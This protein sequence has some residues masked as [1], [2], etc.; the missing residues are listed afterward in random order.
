VTNIPTTMYVQTAEGAYLAYQ[1]LGSGPTDLVLP[2]NGG[3]PVDLM[4]EEPAIAL[5]ISR[6][7]SFSRVITFDPRG[8]GSSSGV[9]PEHVPAV[10]TWMDDIGT[11]MDAV[12]SD[13]ANLLAWGEYS[14]AVMLFAA[15]YPQRVINLVLVN[16]YAR[17]LRSSECPWGMPPD[18]F[19]AYIELIKAAWGTGAVTETLAPSMVQSEEVRMRWARAE[20]LSAAPD[21]IAIPRAFM[22][23]DVTGVV[24]AIQA[25][26]LL[27]SRRGDR[28]VRPEHSRFLATRIS[29][30]RLVELSGD[31]DFLFAGRVDE[32]I[33]NVQ[34]FVTGDRPGPLVDRVLA[35][36]LFTD[37]VGSTATVTELGD[38]LW[39]DLLTMHNDVVRQE[40][41]R[42]RG[43]EIDTAGDGFLI[44]FD[45]PARAIQ[46]G[47]AIRDR[48]RGLGIDI[49]AGLHTGEIMSEGDDVRG[50][51][52]H[53]GARVAALAGASEVLV[54]RTVVD[55]VAGSGI[56]F[57]DRGEH[58]L[59]GVPGFW[60]LFAVD[61]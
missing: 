48:L 46:C 22:E 16:A 43:R 21:R 32:I 24:S 12:G 4:W 20:R 7:A 23:S 27:V 28:H 33:D 56:R 51:A 49:R 53:I 26:T 55:L 34:E 35:T 11:V 1:V 8:F 9:D 40:L 15:T 61:V 19:S 14:S 13:K 30:A 38:R 17:F 25:P 42:F 2:M 44:L 5:G 57:S 31:D 58:E 60:R 39:S 52:V 18:R 6:L 59:K 47:L 3:Y 29:G 50:I 36:V 41:E 45:G 10:Q 37:I 54:S